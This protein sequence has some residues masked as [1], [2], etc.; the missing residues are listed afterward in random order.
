V[1]DAFNE[2]SMVFAYEYAEIVIE[3]GSAVHQIVFPL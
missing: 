3:P 1:I 2:A